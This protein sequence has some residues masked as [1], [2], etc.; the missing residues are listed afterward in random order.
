MEQEYEHVVKASW[1]RSINRTFHQK[2]RYLLADLRKWR[3]SKPKLSDQLAAVEDQLLQEQLKPLNQ[4]DFN[5]QQQL[6]KQHH[7]LLVKDEEF[8][9]QRAKKNWALQGDRNTSYFHQ[10]IVKRTRKNRITYLINPDGSES[11]TQEQLS[12]TLI[13]YFHDIFTSQSPILLNSPN[14]HSSILHIGSQTTPHQYS[15]E[16]ANYMTTG[17]MIHEDTSSFTNSKPT[18]PE[19]YNILKEM[20]S[21]ASPGPDGL[22][23]AFYKSAW[24]WISTDVY[25]LVTQFYTTSFMQP[26]LNQTFIVLIPKK[27][28]PTIPQDFRPISLC[29]VIYKIIAKTL[30][31]RLKPHLPDFIDH[32]QA[33]F[34]KN[35]HISSNVIITQEIIHSFHLKNWTQHAF[36]LKIDLAKAFD[37]LEWS[38]INA[39]LTRLGLQSHFIK[40]IHACIST[41]TFSILVNGEPTEDFCSYRGIRQGCPLSPYLFLVAINELSRAL[42]NEMHNTNLTGITL[43]PGCPPIHSLLFADDLILCGQVTVQEATRIKNILQHFC[44]ASGQVPNL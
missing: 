29:N 7:Q 42:Q 12:Q 23:A 2:T 22:N 30:A 44:Q 19:L 43:G 14:F 11:T 4:Q 17:H 3:K 21:N 40:L 28:Q 6:T 1:E 25:N 15:R 24:P 18:L 10:A 13:T 37:R 5:L 34:I 33:A 9:H 8:H 36:L 20:R 39:G 27:I 32:A 41:P 35:R 26:E 16:E 31:E 38:F